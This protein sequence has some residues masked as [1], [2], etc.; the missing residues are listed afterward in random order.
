M[1]PALLQ[2]SRR[3]APDLKIS[4]TRLTNKHLRPA[5]GCGRSPEVVPGGTFFPFVAFSA[6]SGERAITKLALNHRLGV[7]VEW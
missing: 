5:G 4:S 2:D 6:G 3:T 1:S 7:A